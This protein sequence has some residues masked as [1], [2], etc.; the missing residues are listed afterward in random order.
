MWCGQAKIRWVS[1]L[2][3]W[4]TA[5]LT[6]PRDRD[7]SP[8]TAFFTFTSGRWARMP[9]VIFWFEGLASGRNG[10]LKLCF[11]VGQ[12][13]RARTGPWE[14]TTTRNFSRIRSALE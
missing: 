11:L 13:M 4:V 3:T 2:R 1:Y 12:E 5:L 8:R 6:L 9:G 7:F 14:V 10:M